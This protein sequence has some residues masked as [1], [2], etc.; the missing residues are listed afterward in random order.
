MSGYTDNLS[1]IS[2][3]NYFNVNHNTES[4]LK[5]VDKVRLKYICITGANTYLIWN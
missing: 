1:K 4:P 3:I 2:N 5:F